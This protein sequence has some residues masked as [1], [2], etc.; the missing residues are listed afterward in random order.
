MYSRLGIAITDKCNAAC[1]MCCFG[2]SPK[3]THTLS[4]ELIKDVIRQAGESGEIRTVGFSGGE[5]FLYFDLLL[6]CSSY[7]KSLGLPVSINT[8][9][10]WG[11]NEKRALE[12]LK[13]LKEAGVYLICFSADSY[14]QQ[15]VPIEDLRT[16]MRLTHAVGI[17]VDINIMKTE[18]SDDIVRMTEALR[19]EIYEATIAHHPM[20][21]VGKALENMKSSDFVD[22]IESKD[23]RCTFHSIVTVCFD[24]NYYM[25]CSQFCMEIPLLKLGNANE[26]AF[27]DVK[28]RIISND[29][30]YVMLRNGFGWYVDQARELGY[31]IPERVCTGC[32]CCYLIFRNQKLLDDIRERVEEEAG[33]LRVQHLLG[34]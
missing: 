10:F 9:G 18:Y 34:Q 17:E 26:I 14:H 3:A 24:G 21:P 23:A 5:A 29:Y 6:E 19:P 1:E 25:C 13:A 8:N 11:R 20:L 15:Y 30:L 12:M 4:R 32:H 27:K 31:D 2:C 22:S 7:A 16:A 33:R 28:K